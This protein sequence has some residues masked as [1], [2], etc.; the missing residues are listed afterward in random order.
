[1][2]VPHHSTVQRRRCDWTAVSHQDTLPCVS[3]PEALRDRLKKVHE[4]DSLGTYLSP[5]RSCFVRCILKRKK[6]NAMRT[7]SRIIFHRTAAHVGSPAQNRAEPSLIGKA[8]QETADCLIALTVL[9]TATVLQM[10]CTT[11][12][13]LK[14]AQYELTQREEHLVGLE[15]LTERTP[16]VQR[17]ILSEEERIITLKAK[18]YGQTGD[19]KSDKVYGS[20]PYNAYL[21]ITQRP[22]LSEIFDVPKD[23]RPPL[24]DDRIRALPGVI[25][26]K[27]LRRV[28]QDSSGTIQHKDPLGLLSD[29][30]ALQNCLKA[31]NPNDPAGLYKE[32]ATQAKQRRD[33]IAKFAK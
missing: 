24:V 3:A 1:M 33:C 2:A 30:P 8:L 12:K 25:S 10:G 19:D 11:D 27:L 26:V 15:N 13:E 29:N 9:T 32:D 5:G 28:P 20:G 22:P 18:L 21:V 4:A 17:A 31:A 14:A 16:D 6:Y 23:Q 7:P